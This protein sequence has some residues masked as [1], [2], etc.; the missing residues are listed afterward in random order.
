MT[1]DALLQFLRGEIKMRHIYQPVLIRTLLDNGGSCTLLD[2]ERQRFGF[3]LSFD[4][5]NLECGA[6]LETLRNFTSVSS[7]FYPGLA[8]HYCQAMEEWHSDRESARSES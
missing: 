3:V 1:L 2:P 7:D 5:C 6:E 8:A 4:Q